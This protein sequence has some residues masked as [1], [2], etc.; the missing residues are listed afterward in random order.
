MKA[1]TRMF[2]DRRDA[3]LLDR[4]FARYQGRTLIVH[5]GLTLD[6]LEEL[7]KLGGGGGHFRID[8][9]KPEN[10]DSPVL[11]LAH[12]FILPLN[13]PLPVLCDV[14]PATIAIRHLHCAGRLCH[15]ADIAWILEDMR[16]RARVHAALSRDS[17]RLVTRLG[18]AVG[19]N[20]YEMDLGG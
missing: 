6:W 4:F 16:V 12:H 3:R 5:Q 14:G 11:W 9:R 17:H 1:L 10:R 20:T 13:L 7:L 15:P 2:A 18:L 19:D 8:T